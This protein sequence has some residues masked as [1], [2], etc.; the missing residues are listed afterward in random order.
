MSVSRFA[1]AEAAFSAGRREDGIRLTATE[2]ERDPAAPLNV[3]R[4]FTALLIRNQRYEE[5]ARWGRQAVETYP[6]DFD[7][8]NNLGV[9]LRRLKRFDEALEALDRA[10]KLNPKSAA[11]L[12]NRGN[13]FND[14]RN[15]PAAIA[16][17][18]K[19]VRAAPTNAEHQRALGRA[20]WYAG[21][22]PK[23]EMRLRL[24]TRLKPDMVDAW[25]DLSSVAIEIGGGE[26]GLPILDEAIAALPDVG[27]VHE[28][29]AAMLRR[30]SRHK[31]AETFLLGLQDKFGETGWLNN[32]IGLTV[33]EWDR[34]RAHTFMEKAIALEP[35]NMAYRMALAESLSRTRGPQE[36]DMLEQAYQVLKSAIDKADKSASN[37]K[38]AAEILTRMADFDALERLPGFLEMGRSFAES[39]KHTALMS[40][41]SRVETLDDRL[42]LMEMHRTWGRMVA[43]A[44]A[45]RPIVHP[46]RRPPDGKIRVGFMSSDLR[47]HPVAYFALP[48]FQHYDRSRFEVYCYSYYQGQED[49]TQKQITEW[50]DAFRW[51]P[52]ITDRDAAQKIADDQLDMLIELGGSTHMNKITVMAFKPAPLAASWVGYPHSAGLEEIDYLVVDPYVTPPDPR[53]MIEKPMTLPHAWYALGERAFREE[54]AVNPVAPVERNGYVTFGTA[55]NPYKYGREVLRTWAQIV[56][57]TPGSKFLFVRPE[58]GS[59]SFRTNIQAAFAAEGVTADR[60]VFQPIRG[61]HLP[62]YNDMDISLDTF[63]QTGGTTTCESLWMGVPVITRVGES[64]FERLSYSVL[65]NLDM[66]EFCAATTA[67]YA[68]VAVKLG[69]DPARIGELRRGMRQRMK[70]SPLGATRQFADDYFA[71]IEKA[72]AENR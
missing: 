16:V 6:K 53:L 56:A 35:D 49:P 7:S 19:L 20:Y 47:A 39:G 14:Q 63:P 66:A 25:L 55:N 26:S 52:N 43:K 10:Q 58:G 28:A 3:Y 15:G 54:P 70:D 44:V 8:W 34:P 30:V 46:G 65:M 5:G 40:H 13:I 23:A 29:K 11:P 4:N 37:L 59:P 42:E 67:E 69:G 31:D 61:R 18:T 33:M 9:C 12:I 60:I 21:D 64:M 24:A 57:R 38:V 50:V 27:R 2:L 22:L 36:A 71:M 68:D 51:W 17:W 32:Q 1:E 41:L 72:V 48:L 45:Q 62:F